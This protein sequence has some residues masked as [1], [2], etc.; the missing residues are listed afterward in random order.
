[1]L[2]DRLR[3]ARIHAGLTQEQVAEPVGV[4]PVTISHFERN[5]VQPS[6]GTLQSIAAALSTTVGALLGETDLPLAAGG[7]A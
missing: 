4:H 5:R 3:E 1:M 2:G 7:E 6:L